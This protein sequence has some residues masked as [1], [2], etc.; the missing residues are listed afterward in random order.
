M[1]KLKLIGA[2]AIL[3]ST[4]GLIY[5]AYIFSTLFDDLSDT[6]SLDD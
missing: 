1:S 5:S 6:F 3:T 2:L 4:V